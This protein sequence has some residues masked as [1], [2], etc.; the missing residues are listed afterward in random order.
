MELLLVLAWFGFLFYIAKIRTGT[1]QLHLV[2][3]WALMLLSGLIALI[4]LLIS[5]LR[6]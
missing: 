2:I 3:V 1:L 5:W 6:T 4:K